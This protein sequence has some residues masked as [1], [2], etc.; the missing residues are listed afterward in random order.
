MQI[1]ICRDVASGKKFK[2]QRI[3]LADHTE[4]A[5]PRADYG[6]IPPSVKQTSWQ[7]HLQAIRDGK[8]QLL[9]LETVNSYTYEMT[10]DDGTKEIFNYG[11]N[12]PLEVLVKRVGPTA[13]VGDL[14]ASA[15][16]RRRSIFGETRDGDGKADRKR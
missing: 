1:H 10:A 12:E 16:E 9:K 13:A 5:F 7:E 2:V 14:P 11:G 8:R 6:A 4:I 15:R 3:Q